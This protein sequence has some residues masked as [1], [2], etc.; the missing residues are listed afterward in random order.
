M[1]RTKTRTLR[2]PKRLT[3]ARR[4]AVMVVAVWLLVILLVVG[5]GLAYDTQMAA[6][7]AGNTD[8]QAHAYYTALSGIERLAV[9]LDEGGVFYT[10]PGQPWEAID[11]NSE[12]LSIEAQNYNYLVMA[13]DACGRIDLNEADE[14]AL[15]NIPDL[16]EEQI[17]AIIAFK[18][19]AETAAG[20]TTGTTATPET[21]EA[22]TVKA[23]RSLDDLLLIDG[24][25]P[26]MLFG[27][28]SFPEK[29][30][31]AERFRQDWA[32]KMAG[33]TGGA[34][35]ETTAT[36]TLADWLAVGG[37]ARRIASDGQARAVLT[38][39][40]RQ[41]FQERLQAISEI[42]G[43][44]DPAP[45]T[46]GGVQRGGRDP[47]TSAGRILRGNT[48]ITAWSQVWAAVNNDREAVRLLAD[49]VTLPNTGG[50]TT[51]GAD[52]GGGGGGGGG[53][54]GG[55]GGGGG[56]G[57]GGGGR[58]GGR[59]GGGPGGGGPGGGGPG[60]G[61]PGGGGPGGGGPGGGGPG[62][63]GGGGPR[64]G[65]GRGA[66]AAP[67]RRVYTPAVYSPRRNQ[68]EVLFVQGG[69]GGGGPGGGGPGGGVPGGGG[70]GGTPTGATTTTAVPTG[71][72]EGAIN[73]NT[74]PPEVLM[75]LP[76]MTE[77]VAQAIVAYREENPLTTRGDI[78]RIQEVTPAIFNA[79]VEQ[80]TVMSDT[81]LVRA[82]GTAQG[83]MPGNGRTRDIGV[84]LT[85]IL[86]RTSGR[87]RIVRLRQDN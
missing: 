86:D 39:V 5:L 8:G 60:G 29:L 21:G 80:V 25:T 73:L 68:F 52:A 41:E 71:P 87:C 36:P 35:T 45:S 26:D 43:V 83:L 75:T 64:G 74:A 20:E 78:L 85:A 12:P 76:Q 6:Q 32:A 62:G 63:G 72:M 1:H 70:A 31:P 53:G 10:A 27:S 14:T 69:P 81:Y 13:T 54:R 17:A 57:G 48:T 18:G 61:G 37:K 77:E 33:Q 56:R 15:G 9:E 4:G 44:S 38:E 23:F 16:T 84:H 3:S 42:I 46:G 22:S 59:G 34:S 58:G 24:F 49:V 79:I 65:G 28:A 30:T 7:S 2:K 40:D 47:V 11:G 51:P 55:P 50:G 66:L 82:L 67:A 19:E